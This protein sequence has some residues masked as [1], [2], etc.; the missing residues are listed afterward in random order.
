[1]QTELAWVHVN[2]RRK[3][4]PVTLTVDIGSLPQDS[5]VIEID[6]DDWSRMLSVH[7]KPVT[8]QVRWMPKVRSAC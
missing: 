8:A 1:M 7:G 6:P 2:T 4:E 5:L 3:T